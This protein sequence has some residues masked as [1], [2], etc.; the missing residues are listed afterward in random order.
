MTKR[1]KDYHKKAMLTCMTSSRNFSY[2]YLN[3]VGE[4]GEFASKI[5]KAI[6][7]DEVY[8]TENELRSNQCEGNHYVF[9]ESLKKEAGDILWQLFGLFE[10]M[11]WNADEIAQMN[12]D[13]LKSRQTRNKI[14]GDGDDR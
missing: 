1:F 11:G 3:L 6:R 10:V 5:A 14:D 12:L 9:N 4:I 7:K 13:K 8:I 2:M